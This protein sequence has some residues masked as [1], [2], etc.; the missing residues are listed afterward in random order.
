MVLFGPLIFLI[1][2]ND[3][4]K[5]VENCFTILFADDT[6]LYISSKNSNYLKWCIEH[7]MMLLLDWFH[8]NKLTLNLFKTQFL[9][10][11]SNNKIKQFSININ[12]TA[13]YPCITSKFLGVTLDDKLE[14]TH[15]INE[16][17][18]KIKRNKNMLQ[19]TNNCLNPA[20]KK[21]IY[22][23]QINSHLSHLLFSDMGKFVQKRR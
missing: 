8:A 5:V 15:H 6:T 10:F 16:K 2:N 7:D 9:L 22:Y 17:L 20:A 23:G 12:N 21:L 4:H 18:L 3:L 14:W 13:I 1:F 19:I 11:K